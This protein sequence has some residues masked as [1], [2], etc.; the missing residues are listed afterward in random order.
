MKQSTGSERQPEA[1]VAVML[2]G[3]HVRA[4][5]GVATKAM[6]LEGVWLAFDSRRDRGPPAMACGSRLI[7]AVSEGSVI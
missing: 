4:L 1:G 6:F 5:L 7:G 2:T 3:E